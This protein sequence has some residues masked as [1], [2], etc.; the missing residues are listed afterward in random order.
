M[1]GWQKTVN[2]IKKLGNLWYMKSEGSFPIIAIQEPVLGLI[3]ENKGK[4]KATRKS[5][6][7]RK[8]IYS[9]KENRYNVVLKLAIEE[10]NKNAA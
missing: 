8:R 10:K 7:G 2:Q 9:S 1:L 5:A 6:K 4:K 3:S